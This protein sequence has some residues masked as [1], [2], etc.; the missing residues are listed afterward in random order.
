MQILTIA[1]NVG[2]EPELRTT[3]GGDPVLGFSVAVDQGKDTNGNKR[4]SAWF[5]CSIWGKRAT[6]LQPY[7]NK[8]SKLTLSGRPTARAHDGKAY[9]GLTVYEVTLQ[10]GNT[11]VNANQQHGNPTPDLDDD[12]PF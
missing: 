8:G 9:L 6:A 12:L 2:K 10:G 11:G 4:Q 1:G 7:I 3:Q 5:D